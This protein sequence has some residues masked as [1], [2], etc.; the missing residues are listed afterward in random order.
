MI[1]FVEVTAPALRGLSE[2]PQA[3]SG[4]LEF[5]KEQQEMSFNFLSISRGL[6]GP[7]ARTPQ[8]ELARAV[9]RVLTASGAAIAAIVAGHTASAQTAPAAASEGL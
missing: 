6:D 4:C 9:M 8:G 2:E 3:A 1:T 5:D 7:T